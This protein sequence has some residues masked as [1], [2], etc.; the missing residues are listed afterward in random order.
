SAELGAAA[1]ARRDCGQRLLEE[2]VGG[3]HVPGF[4]AALAPLPH[5]QPHRAPH[6]VRFE[7]TQ[8]Q[9][10]LVWADLSAVP[11]ARGVAPSSAFPG[12]LNAM[13]IDSYNKAGCGY[14]GPGTQQ[15]DWVDLAMRDQFVNYRRYTAARETVAYRDPTRTHL[16]LLD[17]GLADNIGLRSVLQSLTST[18]RPIAKDASG[19]Q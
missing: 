11:I 13:T 5:L 3:G 15:N 1:I 4:A 8:E 17:G 19:G 10:D 12:L 6:R 7:C 16:H 14:T 18:D 9:F 2:R